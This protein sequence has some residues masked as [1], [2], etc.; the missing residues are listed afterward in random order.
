MVDAL[1]DVTVLAK[2]G[3]F[4]NEDALSLA[5]QNPGAALR[6]LN[7]EISQFGGYRR[8]GG[9]ASYDDT[10]G[11]VTGVGQVIGLWILDGTPYAARRNDGDYTGSLGA[12]PFTSSSGS[13][14]ITVAHTSHGLAVSDKV[15]FSGS[16]AVNGI[17]PN[18]VEMTVA[19]VVDANSYTVT[20]T[21]N[22]SGSGSGG[23]S[24]VTF[25]YFDV[26]AAK[27]HALGANP[28]VVTDGSATITVTHTAHGLSVGN[29]VTFSGSSAV[30]GIT[31][32]SV[33]MKI[34]TVADAN[35]YTVSFTSAATSS[36]TGVGSSITAKYS[37][38]Y[39][40]WKYTTSGWTRVHSF[41]SSI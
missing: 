33:E 35:T 9:Y 30:G 17:T 16:S 29:Y 6:M 3:L 37:Q 20:F 1:K 13:A 24:S 23:G 11:T 31:P 21:S 2:G 25:K 5:S 15:I 14:T 39:T 27:A 34:V 28:F 36:A 4:T 22:A 12:N 41:R 7:M 8:I 38:Y 40:I 32:N 26:S 18:D 10:Y 19:S